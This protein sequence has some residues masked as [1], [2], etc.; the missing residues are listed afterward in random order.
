MRTRH[1]LSE[2]AP[3][4]LV[5]CLVGLGF[6]YSLVATTH[7]L[8]GVGLMSL[9]MVVAGGLRAFLPNGR[10]GLLAVRSR[11]FDIVCYLGLGVA[12]FGFGILVPQ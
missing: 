1:H 8:R 7:W 11:P 10:A 9:G 3:F 12:I 4:V 5:V 2:E 6:C